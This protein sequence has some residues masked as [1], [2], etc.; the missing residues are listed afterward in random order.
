MTKRQLEDSKK[1]HACLQQKIMSYPDKKWIIRK[2]EV[3]D[4]PTEDNST[5]H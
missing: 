1:L 3:V 4:L 2:G 5:Q